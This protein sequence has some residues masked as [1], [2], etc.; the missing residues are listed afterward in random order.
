[1]TDSVASPNVPE[2][3]NKGTWLAMTP[4]EQMDVERAFRAFLDVGRLQNVFPDP[5]LGCATTSGWILHA[6]PKVELAKPD[7]L[8][9]DL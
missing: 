8:I 6:A 3:P 5:V 7:Q 2:A 4:D 9:L 1:M